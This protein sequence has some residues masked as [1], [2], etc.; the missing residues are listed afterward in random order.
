MFGLLFRRIAFAA[1]ACGKERLASAR[2]PLFF[3]FLFIL[4]STASGECCRASACVSAIRPQA[5]R[6][7][8][9]GGLDLVR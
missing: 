2:L 8:L 5:F 7:F 9:F 4:S 1:L 3:I 6:G